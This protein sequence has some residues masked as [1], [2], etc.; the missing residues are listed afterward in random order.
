MISC[1][2]GKP[3]EREDKFLMNYESM[4]SLS[5]VLEKAEREGKVVFVDMYAE[6]CLPCK[7]MDEEVYGD[8][9]TADFMNKH[10]INYKV[11]GEKGEGPDLVV[12]FNIKGYPTQLF[13][14]SK[15]R[16]IEKNLGSLGVVGFNVLAD[17]VL[18][19]AAENN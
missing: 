13:L 18:A 7:V 17:R 16:V 1:G 3:L 6:W 14:D 10:F 9:A 2:S 11:D 19:Q 5:L 4:N 12:I 8:K 15:G